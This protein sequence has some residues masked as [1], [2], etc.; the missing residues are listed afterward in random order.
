MMP[1]VL[2]HRSTF[3]CIS[4]SVLLVCLVPDTMGHLKISN[5]ILLCMSGDFMAFLY[6]ILVVITFISNMLQVQ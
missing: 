5:F 6:F 4:L 3:V 1:F 2:L